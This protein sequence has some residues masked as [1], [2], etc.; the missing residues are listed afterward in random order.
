M[1]FL[2][3]GQWAFFFIKWQSYVIQCPWLYVLRHT[4]AALHAWSAM[5]NCFFHGIEALR[6][7][8]YSFELKLNNYFTF[9]R[10]VMKNKI[11]DCGCTVQSNLNDLA[12]SF[13]FLNSNRSHSK[14]VLWRKCMI[15][16]WIER[17]VFGIKINEVVVFQ[18]GYLSHS[19]I[20]I[21]LKIT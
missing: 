19:L 1:D 12:N 18:Q 14:M 9:Y 21:V 15:V 13:A 10:H 20:D 4:C 5:P 8:F 2:F 17:P 16:K 6:I 3:L 7:G 11:Y